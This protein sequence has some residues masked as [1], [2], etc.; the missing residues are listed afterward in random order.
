MACFHFKTKSKALSRKSQ[1]VGEDK[2]EEEAEG[3]T[4]KSLGNI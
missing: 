2:G 4:V 3:V 1:E